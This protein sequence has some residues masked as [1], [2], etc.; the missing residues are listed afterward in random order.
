MKKSVLV[1]TI[2]VFCFLGITGC[3]P[4]AIL[5]ESSDTLSGIDFDAFVNDSYRLL[6]MRDPEG[7]SELGLD[8]EFGMSGDQ[9]TN[10]SPTYISDTQDLESGVYAQLQTFDRTILS[11]RQQITYDV[12]NW[13]LDDLVKGHAFTYKD[14]PITMVVWSMDFDI[15][16][17]FTDLI[18]VTNLQ[19]AENYITRLSLVKTKFDQLIEGLHLRE[20][21]GVVLPRM[22]FDWKMPDL[23]NVAYANARF[24]DFY[25]SFEDKLNE[26]RTLSNEERQDLL[27]RA[28]A[29]I[30]DSVIPAFQEVIDYFTSVRSS[31]PQEIG[32]GSTP[33]GADTYA[34]LLRHHST[35]DLTP[36]EVHQMGLDALVEIQARMR[37]IFTELGYPA[38]DG[39]VDL[40][41]RVAGD[42]GV[43]TD[44]AIYD[45]YV[46]LID[47]AKEFSAD[48]FNLMP[49]VDVIVMADPA[50]G[51]YTP[52]SW[53]GSRPG[54]FYAQVS[55][56][57]PKYLMPDLT[58]HE[59]IPGHHF[60][61]G[62]LPQLDLSMFQNNVLFNGY[63]E[64]WA[65]Y[66]ER[67][68]WEN[69]AYENDQYG[70]LGYLRYQ[71]LRA[72]RLVIDTGINSMGWDFDQAVEFLMENTGVGEG[73]S[74]FEVARASLYPGQSSSYFI[75]YQVI[76]GLRQQMQD[77]LGDG[78]D[79]K[80]FHDLILG[81]GPLPLT[82]LQ[83]VVTQTI[84]GS[85][86]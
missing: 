65:L 26:I 41:N 75:G 49:Q 74:Q 86:K 57:M 56:T 43:L 7:I 44:E 22:Y 34:Y 11:P 31:A 5:Q 70:E 9:L 30:N 25:T 61:F 17:F 66:A 13:Y 33:G 14:Y 69:G 54:M 73:N 59:T 21:N 68:M 47:Y 16:Q 1:A 53:D 83:S 2:L 78:F 71:A 60:Q 79:I 23:E 19:E 63:S 6:L 72:A 84:Q 81:N 18:P 58:F 48:L 42:G 3:K 67:L 4:Q 51:Y 29:A 37:E 24:T 77:A 36:A 39:L 62:I 55:G 64:G 82:V 80:A 8:S 35:S 15:T 45:E 27:D 85:G 52:P 50:G 40:Y 10:I 38:D 12:Y 20:E 46:R 32:I 28:E 76:L